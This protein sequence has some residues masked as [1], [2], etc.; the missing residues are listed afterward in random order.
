MESTRISANQTSLSEPEAKWGE[1]LDAGFQ[2]FPDVILRSQGLLGLNAVDIVVIANITQAWWF[3]DELP[4]LL[5]ASIAKRMGVAER[6]VQRSLAKLRSKGLLKRRKR[7]LGDGSVRYVY[8]LTG[9]RER[10]TPFARREV[11]F[12]ESQISKSETKKRLEL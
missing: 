5:P 1:L 7:I 9:L 8:D 6:T 10:L 3:A 12:S 4:F 2:V 11:R